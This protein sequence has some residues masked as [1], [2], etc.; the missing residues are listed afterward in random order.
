LPDDKHPI[1]RSLRETG[2]GLLLI[3]QFTVYGDCRRGRRPSFDDAEEPSRAEE[4]YRRF[5]EHLEARGFK[6]QEG[7][8]GASMRVLVENDGPVTLLLDS[9]KKF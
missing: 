2:G 4:L 6:P 3:S 1:N 8:F 7:I 5:A 9:E